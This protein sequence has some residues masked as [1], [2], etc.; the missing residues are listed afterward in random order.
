MS[1]TVSI[2]DSTVHLNGVSC[3]KDD[4]EDS[5]EAKLTKEGPP[6][7]ELVKRSS[8]HKLINHK[9]ATLTPQGNKNRHS[10][11]NAITSGPGWSFANHAKSNLRRSFTLPRG[12]L[13]RK[14]G[15]T[16]PVSENQNQSFMRNIF[17]T[18][19]RS[20]KRVKNNKKPANVESIESTEET[21]P[22]AGWL[23]D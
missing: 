3:D 12:L 15:Q 20:S 23:L 7:D 4:V 6:D 5:S 21:S 8:S 22:L 9:S 19:V 11:T 14:S 18:V 1:A 16:G 17:L 10:E 13:N 2:N